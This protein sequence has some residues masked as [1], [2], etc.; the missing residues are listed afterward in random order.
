MIVYKPGQSLGVRS[1]GGVLRAKWDDEREMIGRIIAKRERRGIPL[2]DGDGAISDPGEYLGD[3]ALDGISIEVRALSVSDV[4]R[5]EIALGEAS[6]AIAEAGAADKSAALDSERKAI[7]EFFNCAI[8]AVRGLEYAD[9]VSVNV[10]SP[11]TD[12]AFEVLC[13]NKMATP[14]L[15]AAMWLQSVRGDQRKNSGASQPRSSPSST[16]TPATLKNGATADAM[17]T[18]LSVAGIQ[19]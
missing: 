17:T 2:D 12:E 14:I 16:A 5:H 3:E 9:G 6:R 19:Q 10:A 13:A 18:A 4:Q 15:S 7:R 1:L 11:L 8:V